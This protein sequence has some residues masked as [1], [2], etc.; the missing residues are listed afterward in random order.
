MQECSN[1][2][3]IDEKIILGKL[4]NNLRSELIVEVNGRMIKN[5][6]LFS[7]NYFSHKFVFDVSLMLAEK[8]ILPDEEII[9]I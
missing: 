4:S 7:K 1:Q 3:M 6:P 9:P 2:A 5:F 8:I